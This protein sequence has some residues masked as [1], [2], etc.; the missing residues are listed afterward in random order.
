M[1]LVLALAP[2]GAVT[3]GFP[4]QFDEQDLLG[5]FASPCTEQC[6]KRLQEGKLVL[7]CVQNADTE[8]NDAALKGVR[9]FKA[10]ERFG[11]ATAIVTLDPTDPAE[12]EFLADLQI[13][14]NSPEANTVFLVPPG[15][16]I[17]MFQGATSKEELIANLERASTACGPGGCG[18]GGCGPARA[19]AR[20]SQ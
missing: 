4:G 18:P 1:P 3:G 5:A 15:A 14:P 16:P 10:D 7:L 2:N 6:M 9:D 20:E 8:S 19:P 12:F 13:D 17:A 11:H